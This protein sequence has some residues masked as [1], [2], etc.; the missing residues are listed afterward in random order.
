MRNF[1]CLTLYSSSVLPLLPLAARAPQAPE[2]PQPQPSVRGRDAAVYFP[3][4]TTA[5][6]EADE[7]TRYALADPH[8]GRRAA[9]P[10][11]PALAL[12]APQ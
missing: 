11:K 6:T 9:G 8:G 12:N 4:A 2:A 3:A 5:Q 10:V 1:P 7:Y